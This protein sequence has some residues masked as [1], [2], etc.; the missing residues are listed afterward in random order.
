MDFDMGLLLEGFALGFDAIILGF[1]YKSYES[2]NSYIEALKVRKIS[3]INCFMLLQLAR[4]L[5]I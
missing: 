5:P 3:A 4:N 1:L 2:C